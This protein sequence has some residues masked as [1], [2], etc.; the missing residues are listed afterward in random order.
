MAGPYEVS[1]PVPAGKPEEDPAEVELEIEGDVVTKVDVDY[2]AGCHYLVQT[3]VFYGIKQLWP[4]E[5]GTWFKA[6][7][8]VVTFR[9]EWDLPERKTTLTFKGCSPGTSFQHKIV[10]RVETAD[11]PAAKPWKILDDFITIVKRLTGIE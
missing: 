6:N 1:L 11:L 3:A 4:V 5:P 9:P 2:P 7:K 10:L 8:C